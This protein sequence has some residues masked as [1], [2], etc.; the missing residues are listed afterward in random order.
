M[1]DKPSI[2]LKIAVIEDANLLRKS[3][4]DGLTSAGFNV[5]GEA[6]DGQE[7]IGLIQSSQA[8]LY[9]IDVVMPEVS[10]LEIAKQI[11][12]NVPNARIIMMSSLNLENIIIEA[13][14][15]GAVDFLPKPFDISDLI[16]SVRKVELEMNKEI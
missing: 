12:K 15:N 4:I 6:K 1:N 11:H 2:S 7:A 9:I 13:I 3:V 14:S 10:G 8:N 5:V 16:E